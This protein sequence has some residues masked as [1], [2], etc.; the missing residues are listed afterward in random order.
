MRRNVLLLINGFGVEQ[1]GSYNLYTPELMP[2]LDKL[3]KE[4]LFT[5]MLCT[6]LDYKSGYRNFSIG[7]NKPLTYSLIENNINALEYQ[8]NSILKNIKDMQTSLKSKIHVMCFYENDKTIEHLLVYLKQLISEDND[9][10]IVVHLILCQK[11]LSDYKNMSNVM[12]KINYEY[13]EKVKLCVVTGENLFYKTLNLRDIIKCLVTNAGEK[14]KDTSKK[15]G[16]LTQAKTLPNNARTFILNDN[17]TLDEN[18][19]IFFFNYNSIDI[20]QFKKE[21]G[22]QKYKKLDVSTLKFYSLFPIKCDTPVP[23]MY[24]YAV[25]STCA[26]KTLGEINAKCLIIDTKE[27][28]SYINYYMTGL[29]NSVEPH[30][31]YI[32]NED[33][34]VYDKDKLLE[35]FT[36]YNHEF[37]I[38]NYEIESSKDVEE[39][40]ERLKSIDNIIGAL[41]EYLL[42]NNG[43]MFISSF[44][45]IETQLYNAKHELCKI[46]FSKRVPL[47]VVD[48]FYSKKTDML[49]EGTLYD[50]AKTIYGNITGNL[51]NEG[52]LRKKPSFLSIFYKKSKE[53][54]K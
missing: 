12:T 25:S 42:S 43:A 30:I 38:I 29:R 39:M 1:A 41:S 7:I 53:D 24:N 44:Y 19:I 5:S 14:W 18:D 46:D 45:G 2:N 3:T 22:N 50:L 13:G 23:F 10:V 37:I 26:S 4:R 15:I 27:R 28:C 6:H 21:L 17:L 33:N 20:N 11:S 34:L 51:K 16:V 48:N 54:K 8:N 31:N 40:A 9:S 35:L 47:V 32:P 52:I 36:K 49:L